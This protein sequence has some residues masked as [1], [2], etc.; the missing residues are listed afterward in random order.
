MADDQVFTAE[1]AAAVAAQYA[2]GSKGPMLDLYVRLHRDLQTL[3]SIVYTI[4]G[5]CCVELK[6]TCP[7]CP[8]MLAICQCVCMHAEQCI[9]RNTVCVN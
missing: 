9:A 1:D 2:G 8:L 4:H 7:H 5:S 3:S 6:M